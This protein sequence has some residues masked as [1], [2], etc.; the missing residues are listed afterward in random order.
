MYQ[1]LHI[2][3][4]VFGEQGQSSQLAAQFARTL[5]ANHPDSHYRHRDL[6]ANPIPHLSGE[7]FSAFTT[8]PEARSAAQKAIVAESDALITELRDANVLVLGMPLYNLGVPS[9]FKAWIDHVA[10]AGETF[11]YTESGPEGLLDDKKVYV[12]A[13]RGGRYQETVLDTQTPYLRHILGLLGLRDIEF[14]YAE[15]LN[16]SGDAPAK[17][18]A[19]ARQQL[20]SAAA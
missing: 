20:N 4:S 11:R 13:A 1:I 2:D 8:A 16:M 10:R 7:R 6:N 5:R 15:G 18:L 3:S 14:I 12:F 19:Q 9:T 17:S